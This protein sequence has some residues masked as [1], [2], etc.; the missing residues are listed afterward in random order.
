MTL[1]AAWRDGTTQLLFEPIEFLEKPAAQTPRPAINLLL[2]H[3]ALVPHARWRSQVV[4]YGRTVAGDSD[5]AQGDAGPRGG[6]RLRLIATVHDPAVVHAILAHRWLAPAPD[7]RTG[8]A[9]RLARAT[10]T[11]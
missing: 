7:P 8:P 1:K 2:Y 4:G 3:G 6:G 10:A 11:G 9:P 5:A